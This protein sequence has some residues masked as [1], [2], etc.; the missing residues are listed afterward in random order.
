MNCSSNS[1]NVIRLEYELT[2]LT[3]NTNVTGYLRVDVKAHGKR[4]EM[5]VAIP[6][7]FIDL[8]EG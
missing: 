1:S 8:G 5:E 3:S 4:E 6:L 7:R 2:P